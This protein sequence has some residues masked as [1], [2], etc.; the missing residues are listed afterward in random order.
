MTEPMPMIS[1]ERRKQNVS[2]LSGWCAIVALLGAL[3][4]SGCGATNAQPVASV[5]GTA[6][7]RV[8]LEHWTRI[9][10]IEAESSPKSK[11]TSS[12]AQLRRNALVFLITADWL[13]AEAATKGVV[14]SPSEVNATYHGLVSGPNGPAFLSSLKRRGMSQ[15]DELLE[16]R[17]DNLTTKLENKIGLGD[18]VSAAEIAAYYHAHT[19]EFQPHGHRRQTLATAA[20]AIREALLAAERQRQVAGFAAPYRQRWKLRT[21]CQSGYLVPECRNG[22]PLPA[23]PTK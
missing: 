1:R 20:P 16:L 19:S 6:I 8:A 14:A 17:L 4:L 18:S 13:Q 2:L 7:S 5:Q 11:S 12:P 15:A 23:S 21:T 3:A 10:R 9:K 22:P